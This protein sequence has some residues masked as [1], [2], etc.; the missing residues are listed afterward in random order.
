MKKNIDAE[1]IL[2]ELEANKPDRKKTSLYLS[3]SLYLAF[4][5]TLE[6]RGQTPS[7]VIEKLMAE[8]IEGI[9]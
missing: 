7:A 3:E 8:F 2:K 4:K 9:K 1:K 5:K 6:K